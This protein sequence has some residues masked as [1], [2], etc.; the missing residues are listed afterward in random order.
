MHGSEQGGG[1]GY[2]D[3]ILGSAKAQGDAE[4]TYVF[5]GESAFPPAA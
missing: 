5:W 1:F 4:P 2:G 3:T